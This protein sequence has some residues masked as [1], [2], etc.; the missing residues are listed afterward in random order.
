MGAA[1][2]TILVVG[3]YDTKNAELEFL[4]DV[5]RTQWGGVITMDVSVLGDPPKPIHPW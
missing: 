1:D 5:I 3:T 2:K 4:S